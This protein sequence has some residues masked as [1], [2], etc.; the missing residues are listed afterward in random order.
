MVETK[1]SKAIDAELLD[2][3]LN[4]FRLK[5]I[6]YMRFNQNEVSKVLA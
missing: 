4:Y 1:Q 5:Y 3:G 2:Q 6:Q